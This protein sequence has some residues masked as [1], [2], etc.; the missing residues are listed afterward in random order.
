M[1][2]LEV[3]EKDL[4]ILEALESNARLPWRRLA[5]MLGVSEATIYLRIRRLEELGILKGFTARIDASRM[6][7]SSLM[8][9]LLK[10]DPSRMGEAREK[11]KELP[12]VAE[13]YEVAGDYQLLAKIAAPTH[14][15]AAEA[16]EMITRIEGVKD[17]TSIVVLQT[18]VSDV[19]ITNIYKYWA[20]RA[21]GQ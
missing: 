16:L 19:R 11:L 4:R 10:V 20:T 9:V 17:Y 3:D 2:G 7:L 6:G 14:R 15:E 1:Q 13:A 8:F 18:L 21:G 12:F 5:K